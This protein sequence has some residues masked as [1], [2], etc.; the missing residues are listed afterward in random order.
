MENSARKIAIELENSIDSDDSIL[1]IA[2]ELSLKDPNFDQASFFDQLSEDKDR[3]RL[4]DR[5]RLELAERKPGFIPYWG[6]ILVFP[7]MRR[8]K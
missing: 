2:R 4:N 7:F 8:R 5:Q 6:D 3:I 1:S